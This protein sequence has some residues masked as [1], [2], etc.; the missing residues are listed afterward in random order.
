[1]AS[2]P[3]LTGVCVYHLETEPDTIGPTTRPNLDSIAREMANRSDSLINRARRQSWAI[4]AL[5]YLEILERMGGQID[6]KQYVAKLDE[7]LGESLSLQFRLIRLKQR[8]GLPYNMD[9]VNDK[10][11]TTLFGN[12]YWGNDRLNY[13][14]LHYNSISTTALAYQILKGDSASAQRL[15]SI[16]GYLLEQ[17]QGVYYRNT[18]ESIQVLEILTETLSGTD[19]KMDKPIIEL[20]G[21]INIRVDSF[22]Y[23]QEVDNMTHLKVN[24]IG[25]YPIYFTAYQRRWEPLPDRDGNNFKVR[26][27]FKDQDSTDL[28]LTAG[29]KTTLIAEI[30]VDKECDYIM[31]E[32]PIP[33]GCTYDSKPQP[34]W[35]RGEVHREYF[36]NKCSIFC[37]KM[38][39]GK[40]TYEIPL[41]PQYTGSY[42]LNPAKAEMM[43]F[44]TFFG[45]EAGKRV[46]V[47]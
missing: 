47:K 34:Y 3:R 30:T 43:Y 18:Y 25:K 44:P 42:T 37:T 8:L 24:K 23:T 6:F 7:R 46:H 40:Y 15:S 11:Q 26:S 31:I 14:S 33:A 45:R 13:Y 39:P 28:Q 17:R 19:G 2:C 29:T 16:A 4:E 35:S 38:T 36:R 1:M 5:S 12:S 41:M 9:L 21:G 22:P 32:V 10:R 27:W 20:S